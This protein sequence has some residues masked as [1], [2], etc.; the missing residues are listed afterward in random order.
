Q[1]ITVRNAGGTGPLD[2]VWLRL[3]AN[4]RSGCT[5][6]AITVAAS[7]GASLGRVRRA[8]TALEV[9]LDEPLPR[10]ERIALPLT[11]TITAPDFPDRFGTTEGIYLFGNALPVV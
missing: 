2:R 4:G 10:G 6:Q 3:W 5:A 11:L 7:T 1:T 9:L 8:C